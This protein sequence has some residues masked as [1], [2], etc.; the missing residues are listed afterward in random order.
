M[1]R[2][3]EA[4]DTYLK[5]IEELSK[6]GRRREIAWGVCLERPPFPS[7]LAG[8]GQGEGQLACPPS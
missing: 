1:P 2:I 8:E 6:L 7:P 4:T 5:V 3:N